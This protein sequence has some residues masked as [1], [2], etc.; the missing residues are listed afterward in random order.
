MEATGVTESAANRCAEYR[1]VLAKALLRSLS[2]GE[3][4]Y[5]IRVLQFRNDLRQRDRLR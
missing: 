3:S 2:T 1:A 4:E 5:G